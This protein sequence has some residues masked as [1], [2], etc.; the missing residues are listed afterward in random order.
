[1]PSYN[2]VRKMNL[3]DID[4]PDEAR[5]NLR[6]GPFVVQDSSNVNINGG[7]IAI[8]SL[9]INTNYPSHEPKPGLTGAYIISKDDQGTLDWNHYFP[10]LSW[11]THGASNISI[12]AFSNDV[13]FVNGSTLCNVSLYGR[14]SD[15][16]DEPTIHDVIPA[17]VA[18]LL[19]KSECNLQE[20]VAKDGSF[21]SNI[22]IDLF[23]LKS[24]AFKTYENTTIRDVT[25]FDNF[26]IFGNCNQINSLLQSKAYQSADG[27]FNTVNT[28]WHNPFYDEE[29]RPRDIVLLVDSYSNHSKT[30]STTAIALSNMYVSLEKIREINQGNFDHETVKTTIMNRMQVGEFISSVSNFSE[31]SLDSN[32]CKHNLGLGTI[33]DLGTQNSLHTTTLSIST[34]ITHNNTVANSIGGGFYTCQDNLGTMI[35]TTLPHATEVNYGIVRLSS[36]LFSSN[37]DHEDHVL[38]NCV[39]NSATLCNMYTSFAS[40]VIYLGIT[41]YSNL[42]EFENPENVVFLDKQLSRFSNQ[43]RLQSDAHSNLEL[44]PISYDDNYYRLNA[45]PTTLHAFQN[46]IGA[47]LK[48]NNLSEIY[49]QYES[50][51]PNALE[52]GTMAVENRDGTL[53]HNGTAELSHVRAATMQFLNLSS[54]LSNRSNTWISCPQGQ[55]QSSSTAV[56]ANMRHATD[57]VQGLTKI[58][59]TYSVASYDDVVS[60]Q[61]VKDMHEYFMSRLTTIEARLNA[62]GVPIQFL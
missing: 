36:N 60:A 57:T 49:Q 45:Y 30:S 22:L 4:S 51:Y 8:D 25:V 18:P 27:I 24:L 11:A 37:V 5:N 47:L 56:L 14:F 1:M 9:A 19:L 15:L 12:A 62:Y 59:S 38:S 20:F 32:L 48:H 21:D 50:E 58:L 41:A 61:S 17:S 7:T 42:S 35:P 3:G 23:Q 16:E 55:D 34:S 44:A 53:I 26:Y 40:N 39:V 33:S 6:I 43:P 28:D 2:L 29:H 54:Q 46:D 13:N 10:V 52:L 31:S